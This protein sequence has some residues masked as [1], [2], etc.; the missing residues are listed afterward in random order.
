MK[1]TFIF[2]NNSLAELLYYYLTS[3]GQTIDGFV[4]NEKYVLTNRYNLPNKLI[5]IE[6]AILQFGSENV[7]VYVTIGYSNMNSIRESIYEWLLNINI[8]ILSYMHPTCNIASNTKMGIGNIFLENTVIQPFSCIGNVN[9]F[10]EGSLLSHHCEVGNFNYFSPGAVVSGRVNIGN[11][12]FLGSNCTVKN[13]ITIKDEVL[14]GAGAYA[15]ESLHAGCVFVPQRGVK[16]EKSSL[17][18]SKKLV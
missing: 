5:S 6:S 12:C 15:H 10:W 7:N 3:Q 13:D 11:R 8:N 9:I 14:I 4:V 2:G 16:L 17:Q 1:R 18:I